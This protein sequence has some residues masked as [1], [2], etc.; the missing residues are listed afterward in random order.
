MNRRLFFLVSY[1]VCFLFFT[2]QSNAATFTVTSTTND[3][4]GVNGL[5]W[6][7]TQANGA[8]A[9]PH[10]ILLTVDGATW[11]VG[12]TLT[13]SNVTLMAAPSGC[14]ATQVINMG[15]ANLTIAGNNCV[16]SGII[17]RG[18]S[19]LIT[20]SNN[21]VWGCWF[22]TD[23]TGLASQG[24][25]TNNGSMIY[26]NGGANNTVGMTGQ[27]R[28]VFSG[29]STSDMIRIDGTATGT[30]ISNN[31]MGVGKNGTTALSAAT[32]NGINFVSGNMT[33]SRIDSNIIASTVGD[34][35]KL[36]GDF[37]SSFIRRNV[38]RQSSAGNGILA[39]ASSVTSSSTISNNT[40]T[41]NAVNGIYIL[42]TANSLQITNNNLGATAAGLAG[43]GLGN[44]KAGLRVEANTNLLTISGNVVLE[45]GTGND[46]AES[47]G[48]YIYANSVTMSNVTV[49]NNRVGVDATGAPKGN[50]FSGLYLQGTNGSVNNFTNVVVSGNIVGD[51]GVNQP[52]KKSH[53]ISFLDIG[54][55]TPTNLQVLN[56]FIG[57]TPT[58]DASPNANV[59]NYGNGIEL[60]ATVGFTVSG[61]TVGF[62]KFATTTGGGA[63]N[64][65]GAGI[66][67]SNSPSPGSTT[68]I[69]RG[70]LIGVTAAGVNIGNTNATNGTYP[71][72]MAGISI[73]GS[74]GILIG[75]TTGAD[76]NT[77][78]NN[79][80]GIQL[81]RYVNTVT[82]EIIVRG[83]IIS[84]QTS[85]GIYIPNA[86]NNTIGSTVAGAANVINNNG[87][88]GIYISSSTTPAITS[89][90]NTISRNQIYCNTL[91][92]IKLN[93]GANQ[94]NSGLVP[95][96]ITS[97]S[98]NTVSGTATAGASIEIFIDDPAC[99]IACGSGASDNRREG[100]TYLTTV[101]ATGG[102]WTYTHGSAIDDNNVSAT[103]TVGANTSEFSYCNL[104]VLCPADA[105]AGPNQN[106]CNVTT[107]TLAGNTVTNGG[108][109]LWTVVS[110][111]GTVTTPSSPTSGVTGLVA[112]TPLVLKW[113]ITKAGCPA[114]EATVTINVSA[115]SQSNA[116]TTQNLCNVT[117]TNLNATTTVGTGVWTGPAG[118]VITTPSSP[119]SG[120]TGLQ[121][122][123][124]TFTWTVTNG[125]CAAAA[126]TVT[127]NV[128]APSQSNAGT[129]QA[130]CNVTTANLNATTTVGTGAW[131]TSSGA[132]ITTPSSPTSGVTGLSVGANVFTW[133]VT[134]GSCTAATSTVTITVSAPSQSNAGTTQ[135]LCNVTTT[136]LNAT[137]TVGT[138]VWTTSSGAT[139]TTP[140]SPTSGVTGLAVGANVFTWTVTNGACTAATSTVTVNVSAPS[141]SN[142]G[143]AQALCNVTTANLNATT[144]VGT[145]AW[146]TSSGATI[147]T[148]SS[149]TSG[150]TGLA[151][152]ANTFTWTVTNGSCTAATSTVTITVSAPSQS[153]AGTAQALCNVTTANL[154]ATTTVGTGAWT[155]SS[156]ATIT[157]PSSP[158]SG[159]T[160]LAVGANTF[161]W[162]VTNGSCAAATSNVTI[163]VSAPSQSNAGTTQNLCNVTTTNLNATTTV[164]TGVWT[165]P[166]GRVIT[167]P[168]S[169]TSGVT[170]LQV[171]ANTF[172][173]TV[174]NGACAAAATTVTVNVSAPSQSNAGTAQALCNV[175][176]ANL[177]A[178]TT[179]GTGAWTTSSGATITTPS[180]P[181][182][183]VTG[184]SVGANVFT[185]TVTNGSCT[186]ATS[187][188]TITVSAPSQ[189]NAGAT[190]DLCN[191]TTGT[192]TA[193]TTVGTGVWTGPAGRVIT[194]PNS[195]STG[196][197][198]LQVGANTFT[199]TVTN[200]SCTAAAS[201]VTLNVSAPSQSNAGTAQT[202]CNVTTANLN[203]TTTVGTGVWTTS[204]GA[205]ITTPSSPTSSVSNLTVGATHTFTWTV[206]NGACAAATSTVTITINAP[207]Q[208]NAGSSQTLCNAT[209]AT[210]NANT[211]ISA[212][213]WTGPA[214]VTITSPNSPNTGVTGLTVGANVF[215][216]TVTNGVCS[217]VT[218]NV[219]VTVEAPSQANAGSDQSLCNVT[220]ASLNAGL[221]VG[222]GVWTTSS[223]ATITTPSSPT[224][225]V[226]GLSVGAN[227]FTWTVTNGTCAAAT[228]TTTITVSA[229]GTTSAGP[230]Q[231]ICNNTVT[232]LS[233]SGTTGNWTTISGTG[234]V[235]N[236][237]SPNSGVTGLTVG[238]TSV[239]RW[240]VTSG[241][242]SGNDEVSVT[243]S[244]PPVGTAG[245]DQNLCNVTITDLSATGGGTWVT[246][247]GSGVVTTPANPNSGVTGLTPG[248]TS[249][250]TWTVVNG[251]CTSNYPLTVN[252]SLPATSDAGTDQALCNAT[253]TSL[254][255]PVGTGT[256][257]TFSGTGVATTPNSPI[258]DVT[259][260][261]PGQTTVFQWMV[262]NGNCSSPSL[263]NIV[264]SAPVTADAG[265]DILRCN[266]V[267][268]TLDAVGTGTWSVV[269][270]T[271][272]V[273]NVN[274]GTSG[275]SNLTIGGS[276]V[277]TWTVT[278]GACSGTDDVTVTV[279]PGTAADAGSAQTLCN[280]ITT[281]LTAVAGTN[282]TWLPSTDATIADPSNPNSS[283]TVINSPATLTWQI[284]GGGCGNATAQVT[285]TAVTL[286]KPILDGTGLSQAC[287]GST[288]TYSIDNIDAAGTY[289]WSSN[290]ASGITITPPTGTSVDVSATSSGK[291]IVFVNKSGC[292]DSASAVITVLP[293]N[294]ADADTLRLATC[295]LSNYVIE[296]PIIDGFPVGTWT[297]EGG[298]LTF[299]YN[300]ADS[301][302]TIG[303]I[304]DNWSDTLVYTVTNPCGSTRFT[305]ILKIGGVFKSLEAS[306]PSDTLCVSKARNLNAFVDPA[307]NYT[308]YWVSNVNYTNPVIDASVHI[309]S[310][311]V[312]TYS[313][314][315]TGP[316]NV[317][318]VY[319]LDKASQCRTDIDTAYI[320]AVEGQ[321]LNVPNLITPN[322]DNMNDYWVLRDKVTGK[323]ILPG[324]QFDLYNRWGQRVFG[325]SDYDNR[326]KADHISDGIYYFNVKSGCGDKEYKGWLQIL[327]NTNP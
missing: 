238:A 34:G 168:S 89:N 26:I 287:S 50:I 62:N 71:N 111:S 124:N 74:S 229:P 248:T 295:L 159:V 164:G 320:H 142:A 169:P 303:P 41:A 103:A 282:G 193:T 255:A 243:V 14:D 277:F 291:L 269:S 278:N 289:T 274:S 120:V 212:G 86:N 133:T 39:I 196:V 141:Q 155:T 76:A 281:T 226:T 188:V 183:G 326:F 83:N 84:N 218:S 308:Y 266:D 32:Q 125:A 109:G 253:T 304:T 110:G 174:T 70:N 311:T 315:P 268:A 318:F 23:A 27:C 283:V 208:S 279:S 116:G 288:Y 105:N 145:G 140:S 123:A 72:Q 254:N 200:G 42:G 292:A 207:S 223:G 219:T 139:I 251:F 99:Q 216:W 40:I 100:K 3:P 190:Q 150:V 11:G 186:A 321:D 92:G 261:T 73:D 136:N 98:G 58:T 121:V 69:I 214:G 137:T 66:L 122:G 117:T 104:T 309:D 127:V 224:S 53:G 317:Y 286:D 312:P 195:S 267:T 8:G 228:A 247:S 240:T 45:N 87:G 203:A 185:W 18:T 260:L 85:H 149:P 173:W 101:T 327:G 163:T 2:L 249:V 165:G 79:N 300:P 81:R 284:D 46:L 172:T 316:N 24:V 114:T 198:G 194:S 323:D 176:T 202:L 239:F 175:T 209:T 44:T 102:N 166:A 180:S 10:T 199:W 57:V 25:G 324:S 135:N 170:G 296:T 95:P 182:S 234:V 231:G 68:G 276:S 263:V 305:Y 119:T 152:G 47:S 96:V 131:T 230:D 9:G 191:V 82:S 59:G 257:T 293:G 94:G 35:I 262:T 146:T 118:R 52:T 64:W 49:S 167:T 90:N 246:T 241:A 60:A 158:T 294:P 232:N 38:I 157:T 162:T 285:I 113:T 4:N 225:G 171:G 97:V 258:S 138:G 290:P 156:G 222:T 270:G 153:N 187:T 217:S 256:W 313:V 106:L 148:P 55:S 77:I 265:S 80:F 181:T 132:T 29:A 192:L 235:T 147:T 12:V 126:T 160:G 88:Q 30:I 33:G 63:D 144:T 189:S 221:S 297:S 204:S 61:N 134:N 197:S 143:T 115:P 178:T 245:A 15:G 28:N 259:G 244:A 36:G 314:T 299:T 306:G 325:M 43:T 51:N 298:T 75:G 37:S 6:A 161:T 264:S 48:I 301:T 7:I 210:L 242:C 233:G 250:F 20:G 272:T 67:V 5:G 179:V 271:G 310:T 206:T 275:V 21:R 91:Q 215:T 252:V 1:F 184:L 322:D 129:A 236:P 17:F 65:S 280:E 19:L 16:I 227:T 54:P 177:N 56:N 108:A 130:L 128:S 205:T 107:A 201:T 302:T 13:N 273:N 112:G 211:T 237:T 78:R 220:S 31:Y 154:N 307:G 319:V 93:Y 213:V 151:V 22:N